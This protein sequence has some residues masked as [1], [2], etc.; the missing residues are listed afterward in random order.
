M[1]NLD[2][3]P[4]FKTFAGLLQQR[5]EEQADQRLYSFLQD[6][7]SQAHLSY[8]ELFTRAQLIAAHLQNSLQ[9]EKSDN[10]EQPRV[11][12]LLPPGL[13][14]IAAFFGC[15]LAG[16][17]AVPLPS[18]HPARL[19][20]QKE[21]VLSIASDAQPA[22]VLCDAATK[23][24]LEPIAVEMNA[25][26]GR[27]L[28]WLACDELSESVDCAWRELIISGQTTAFL[29]YTS[30]STSRPKGVLV[31]H[32]NLLHNCGLIYRAFRH[33]PQSRGVIWLP[34]YHD[35]GLIG[36]VLQ[37]L[38]GGFPVSLFSPASFLM[39]PLRWL[40]TITNEKA[41]TSGAPN[42]AYELCARKIT[43]EQKQT[44]DLSSWQVAFVGA[45]P[46]REETLDRFAS[47]FESCGFAREAFLPCYGLAESTLLVSGEKQTPLPH[48]IE[49]NNSRFVSCGLA[50]FDL[51]VRIADGERSTPCADGE[52]GEV[53]VVGKSVAQGYWNRPAETLETFGATLPGLENQKFLRTGD[54][55]FLQNGELFICGREKDLIVINGRNHFPEDIE[56]T[57]EASNQA[58]RA[59]AAFGAEIQ[60]E[61]RLIVMA[62]IDRL[63]QLDEA[64]KTA[65]ISR[66][67][68]E[69]AARHDLRTHEVILQ[70]VGALPR[71]T[72]GKIQRARCRREYSAPA[73]NDV[74]D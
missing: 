69:V 61:E 36:G 50:A 11:L 74:N 45:E 12:L 72:S 26:A 42:F 13:E 70:R 15:L 63:A 73:E 58:I 19:N 25:A 56:Y 40:Q 47:A 32:E 29:Q 27:I 62:E 68:I 53:F 6:N 10:T 30:G 4:T 34:P 52:V 44:L 60:N 24:A 54:L 57:I 8:A 16:M 51:D 7:G 65:L 37:P 64:E 35:M 22:I 55:G 39:K 46:V 59:A 17:I 21:R 20:A 48:V 1:Q 14:L 31:S 3:L 49:K 18:P 43:E 67:K 38:F 41:T 66:I 5:A 23:S 28:T 2:S 9:S 33:S 71:T